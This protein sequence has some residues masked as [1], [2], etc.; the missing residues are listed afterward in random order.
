MIVH[1]FFEQSG[2]FRNEFRKYGIES[3]DYDI[4][5]DYGTTDYIIDLFDE[6]EKAYKGDESV[7]DKV[8]QDD[9]IFAFFPCT[10]FSAQILLTFWQEGAQHKNL[11][12]VDKLERDIRLQEELTYFYNTITK[13][14]IVAYKKRLKMIIENPYGHQHYLTTHWCL[15]PALIDYDRRERGDKL[16]KPTQFFFI[17]TEPKYNVIFEAFEQ[18]QATN[19]SGMN[20]TERS[21]ITS[22]YAN[23]FIRE[24]IL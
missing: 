20:S 16:K 2:T 1:C 12:I 7:F 14:A 21:E 24:F 23:R 15:K 22:T 6:I 4:R 8:K 19:I 9:L 17:N 13:M 5:N 3:Y 11:P 10:K 18:P